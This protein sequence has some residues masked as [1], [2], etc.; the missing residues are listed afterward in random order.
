MGSVGSRQVFRGARH[1][2]LRRKEFRPQAWATRDSSGKILQES[3][4]N[5]SARAGDPMEPML[6]CRSG[7]SFQCQTFPEREGR[8]VAPDR[9]RASLHPLLQW[10]PRERA[11]AQPLLRLTTRWCCRGNTS[12]ADERFLSPGPDGPAAPCTEQ[13]AG[14][15]RTSLPT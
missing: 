11:R 8:L 4:A 7:G 6:Q 2:K 5:G 3:K 10:A 14:P 12:S 15:R 13:G 9:L 1:V